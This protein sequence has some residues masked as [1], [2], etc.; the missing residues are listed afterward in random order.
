LRALGANR[1]NFCINQRTNLLEHHLLQHRIG[2]PGDGV[3]GDLGAVHLGQVRDDHALGAVESD[4]SAVLS[5]DKWDLSGVRRTGPNLLWGP[6]DQRGVFA[7]D[8]PLYDSETLYVRLGLQGIG[9]HRCRSARTRGT[10]A[11]RGADDRA[12][13]TSCTGIGGQPRAV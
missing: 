13:S 6:L 3:A 12:V 5:G 10:R 11:R 7:V 2:D 9:R 1:A 4:R 8:V